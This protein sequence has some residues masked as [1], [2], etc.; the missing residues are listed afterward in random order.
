MKLYTKTGDE[1]TTALFGGQRVPKYH[2]RVSAY[3]TLDEANSFI[4]LAAAAADLP[5]RLRPVLEEVMSDLFDLGAEL[6]T[7]PDED[8]ERRLSERLDNRIGE[9]R[10]AA[11]ERLIDETDAV[12][13]LLKTFVLPTG[14]EA[15]ARLHVA[16]TQVRR[17]ERA[18]VELTRDEAQRVRPE[19]IRYLNR[20]SDALFAFARLANHQEGRADTPWRALKEREAP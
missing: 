6:A 15:A 5:Q 20:L 9:P 19:V 3:G 14:T 17:A 7:P 18:I 11:L 2:P 13:P 1:G 16:R 12:L 8:A 10:I 4:G